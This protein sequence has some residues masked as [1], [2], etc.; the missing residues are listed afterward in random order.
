VATTPQGDEPDM[1]R[2]V[3]GA[4]AR[5]VARQRVAMSSPANKPKKLSATYAKSSAPRTLR[6]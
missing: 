4:L 6:P 5:A 3:M 2:T 1:R